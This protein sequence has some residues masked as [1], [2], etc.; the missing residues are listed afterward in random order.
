MY[1]DLIFNLRNI[2]TNAKNQPIAGDLFLSFE[3]KTLSN[4]HSKNSR[5]LKFHSGIKYTLQFSILD[6][7]SHFVEQKFT[8]EDF[9]VEFQGFFRC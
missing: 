2:E 1:L 5:S 8:V 9:L 7:T 4:L 3:K 6:D